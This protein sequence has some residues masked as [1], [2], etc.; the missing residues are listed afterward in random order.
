MKKFAAL[1]VLLGF[2]ALPTAIYAATESYVI[3]KVFVVKAT[4]E[5]KI[6]GMFYADKEIGGV[7]DLSNDKD[8]GTLHT[9]TEAKYSDCHSQAPQ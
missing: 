4:P 8:S 6:A 2:F 9:A 5:G 7:L 1:T 3:A